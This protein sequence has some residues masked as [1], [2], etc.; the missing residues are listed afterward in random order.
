VVTVGKL[1]GVDFQRIVAARSQLIDPGLVD[2]EA[3]GV[4]AL[5]E[6]HCERQADIT[7]THNGELG[8]FQFSHTVIPS[9]FGWPP[10]GRM[11]RVDINPDLVAVGTKKPVTLQQPERQ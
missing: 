9:R 8:V 7:E 3:N 1:G 10:W 6:L 5:A 2:V 4:V 11:V